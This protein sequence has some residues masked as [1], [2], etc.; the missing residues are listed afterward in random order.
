MAKQAPL[1]NWE[2][3]ITEQEVLNY[4][5]SLLPVDVINDEFASRR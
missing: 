4:G 1:L 5:L 2:G 3:E